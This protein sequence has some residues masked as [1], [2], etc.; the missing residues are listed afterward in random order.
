MS[1]GLWPVHIGSHLLLGLRY[2]LKAICGCSIKAIF[3]A[4]RGLYN[5]GSERRPLP[6]IK[7]HFDT[8]GVHNLGQHPSN[9]MCHIIWYV[10]CRV[11]LGPAVSRV[12]F[13]SN[14]NI[15]LQN[16]CRYFQMVNGFFVIFPGILYDKPKNSRDKNLIIVALLSRTP[17]ET[18]WVLALLMEMGPYKDREKLWPGWSASFVPHMNH[19]LLPSDLGRGF[20]SHPGQS[21]SLSL[22]G[23]IS[24]SRAKAHMVPMGYRTSTSQNTLIS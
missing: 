1:P 9:R 4:G 7:T 2:S 13:Y 5:Y 14:L 23:P 24:I 18:M 11:W 8:T 16:Q 19:G 15:Y 22:C 6:W 17:Y 21:F 3:P 12:F 20:N 10:C